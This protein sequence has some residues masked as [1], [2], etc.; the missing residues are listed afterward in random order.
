LGGPLKVFPAEAIA[1]VFIGLMCGGIGIALE[2]AFLT[3]LHRLLWETAGW[4]AANRTSTYT[5]DFVFTA[6]VGMGSICLGGMTVILVFGGQPRPEAGPVAV[7]PVEVKWVAAAVLV[8]LVLC[9]TWVIGRYTRLLQATIQAISQ[10]EPQL[11][12]QVPSEKK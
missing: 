8:A 1:V 7:L 9:V 5:M 11:G 2:F 6:V 3:V 4:Q 10:P 12:E